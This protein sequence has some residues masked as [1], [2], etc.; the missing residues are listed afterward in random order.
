MVAV[1]STTSVPVVVGAAVIPLTARVITLSL[2][3]TP[4]ALENLGGKVKVSQC[5]K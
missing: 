5:V 4:V 2:E 1:V 3:G